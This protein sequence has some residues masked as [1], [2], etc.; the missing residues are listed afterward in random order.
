MEHVH[1]P[2]K[3]WVLVCDGAKSLLFRND[4]DAEL[5]NLKAVDVLSQ[6]DAPARDLGTERPGRV[7][8]SHGAARSAVGDVDRHA[9]AEADFL[10][11]LAI[12]LGKIVQQN[13]V[14]SLVIVAPP[15]ALGILRKHLPPAVR[16]VLTAEVPKDL[17]SLS[18][19]EI[20]RH[21]AA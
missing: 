7:Y 8:Q 9:Q 18:T 3:G 10:A 20:E 16:D 19:P 17:A 14:N 1:I 2:W 5:L 13:E 11:A 15:R 21:L 6:P 4:G 12:Q